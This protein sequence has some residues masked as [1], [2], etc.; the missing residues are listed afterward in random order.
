M[1]DP[2][3]T[4][5]ADNVKQC[6][7][8]GGNY[9]LKLGGDRYNFKKKRFCSLSCAA[10]GSAKRTSLEQRLLACTPSAAADECWPWSGHKTA[11]GYGAFRYMGRQIY[12]HRASFEANR[13]V[14]PNG[15]VVCHRC[16]NPPC[17]NPGHLFLGT[18]KDNIA[19]MHMKGRH[20]TSASQFGETHNQAKLTEADVMAIRASTESQ[21]EIARKY[22]V[23]QATINDIFKRKTWRHI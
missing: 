13:G 22:R 19:D 1:A 21:R 14:I 11:A 16:D 10:L 8:C 23:S 7:H 3:S 4:Y 17:V 15:M 9:G 18:Q 5:H 2:T 6:E 12:A 20:A